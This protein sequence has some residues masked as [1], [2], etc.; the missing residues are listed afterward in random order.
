MPSSSAEDPPGG[1]DGARASQRQRKPRPDAPSACVSRLLLAGLGTALALYLILAL[2]TA[3]FATYLWDWE[4]EMDFFG[5]IGHMVPFLTA[6]SI[7]ASAFA[8]YTCGVI[9]LVRRVSGSGKRRGIAAV[10]RPGASSERE[11]G[12]RS[13]YS[14]EGSLSGARDRP[15]RSLGDEAPLYPSPGSARGVCKVHKACSTRSKGLSKW[16]GPRLAPHCVASVALFLATLVEILCAGVYYSIYLIPATESETEPYLTAGLDDPSRSSHICFRS[17]APER[18]ELWVFSRSCPRW[19]EAAGALSDAGDPPVSGDPQPC[20]GPTREEEEDASLWAVLS[21]DS[22][23][24]HCFLLEGLEPST[25]YFY[26]VP[27]YSYAGTRNFSTAPPPVSAKGETDAREAQG[28]GRPQSEKYSV[29]L[30]ADT[31]GTLGPMIRLASFLQKM[32]PEF[33]VFAGD[34]VNSGVTERNWQVALNKKGPF[35]YFRD[36][37]VVPCPGNHEHMSS[38]FGGL[39]PR[40]HYRSVYGAVQADARDGEEYESRAREQLERLVPQEYLEAYLDSAERFE[41]GLHSVYRYGNS[42]FVLLD[43]FDDERRSTAQGQAHGT[44]ISAGQLL[45]LDETLGRF[46]DVQHRFLVLHVPLYSTGDY[47][48]NEPLARILEPFI[49]RH[50]VTAVFAGHNHIFEVFQRRLESGYTFFHAIVSPAGGMP[51]RMCGIFRAE[52][53]WG[54]LVNRVSDDPERFSSIYGFQ[55]QIVAESRYHA[56]ILRVDGPDVWLDAYRLADFSLV[57]S[58]KI[59]G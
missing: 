50:R 10:S 8:A 39:Y 31:H 58:G 1:P 17:G 23:H 4:F 15:E 11:Y 2:G 37:V 33:C 43:N 45:W 56:A 48:S 26:R 28:A 42:V 3:Y 12:A 53:R 24:Y 40:D 44:F 54:S 41:D 57:W 27:T 34:S 9:H 30:F 13:Q 5:T 6:I 38:L 29:G 35:S 19:P 14:D 49:E 47:E 20:T 22:G 55:D 21:S 59:A 7:C 36:H 18:Q 46:Q 16:V 25:V 51:D 32:G 52:R